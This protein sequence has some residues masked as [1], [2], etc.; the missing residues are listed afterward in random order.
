MRKPGTRRLY[1]SNTAPFVSVVNK[2]QIA[3]GTQLIWADEAKKFHEWLGRAILYL[4]SREKK[5]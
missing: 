5:K 3:I 1:R 2:H 4:E